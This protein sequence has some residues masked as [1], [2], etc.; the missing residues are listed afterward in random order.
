MTAN[1]VCVRAGLSVDAL[2][3]LFLERGVSGA[4]VVDD[5]GHP[6]GIVSKTDLV[7]QY[8]DASPPPHATAG[9]I[10][11]PLVF[12]LPPEATITR[13]AALMA[14]EGVHRVPIVS[15]DGQI[16]GLLSALDIVRWVAQ[17]DEPPPGSE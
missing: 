8:H 2:S 13:A 6:I 14:C 3:A 1:V 7:Q 10:M 9:D 11:M 12:S 4:P 15:A 16:V 5:H 17:L